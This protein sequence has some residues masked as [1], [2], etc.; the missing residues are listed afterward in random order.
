MFG[1]SVH[2]LL[3]TW[4]PAQRPEL[5]L[6]VTC[7]A[8]M[9]FSKLFRESFVAFEPA[10]WTS[11]YFKW[12]SLYKV[13]DTFL[14]DRGTFV[15]THRFLGP[16]KEGHYPDLLHRGYWAL[17]LYVSLCSSGPWYDFNAGQLFFVCPPFFSCLLFMAWFSIS[18]SFIQWCVEGDKKYA[19]SSVYPV[20]D[21]MIG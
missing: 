14:Y 21:L 20:I 5:G 10:K 18:V 7:R 15:S 17:Q 4:K 1:S 13:I 12:F 8:L 19:S 2:R 6:F 9:C 3:H 11:V 16:V